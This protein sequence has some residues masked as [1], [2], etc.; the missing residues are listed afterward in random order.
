MTLP[1]DFKIETAPYKLPD[2]Y[3]EVTNQINLII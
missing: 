3:K 1:N 2:N